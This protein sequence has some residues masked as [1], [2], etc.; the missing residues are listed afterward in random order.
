LVGAQR[1]G[2]EELDN[3]F[4]AEDFDE[5]NDSSEQFDEMGALAQQKIQHFEKL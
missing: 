5:D 4:L 3:D 2:I 1:I